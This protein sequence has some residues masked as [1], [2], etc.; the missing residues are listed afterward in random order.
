MPVL[1]GVYPL[2]PSAQLGRLSEL[3][4]EDVDV[5]LIVWLLEV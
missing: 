1:L 2:M 5:P 4:V 3:D